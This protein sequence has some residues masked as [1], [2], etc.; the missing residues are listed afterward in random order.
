VMAARQMLEQAE[1]AMRKRIAALPPG[2]LSF[3]DYLDDDG[4]DS[5]PV[6]VALDFAIEGDGLVFDF[7]RSDPQVP[8]PINCTRNVL[9]SAVNYAVIA[10]LGDGIPVNSGCYAPVSVVA[11]LGRVVN[12]QAPAPVVNRMTIAH[13]IVN[14]V[15]GALAQALPR[16]IPAA[17][18]G[19]SYVCMLEAVREDGA[20]SI[21][22]DSEVGGWGGEPARDG[23]NAFSCGLHNIAA[24]PIEM[25]ESTHPLLFTAYALRPDSGGEGRSRG[26]VGLIREWRLEAPAGRF[27]ATFDRFTIAPY[28]LQGG[29]PGA[30]GRLLLKRGDGTTHELRSKVSDLELARGDTI[31]IETSGGGGYGPPA[32]RDPAAIAADLAHGYTTRRRP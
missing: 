17:Y 14:A 31:R 24:V 12:A 4:I 10:A 30:T 29:G 26:G 32:E 22:F 19:V 11:P 6:K 7:S 13:R 1:S 8:V 27:A 23:A 18:Y 20:R 2:R 9:V 28:G 21:Y 16:R 5:R 15:M 25:L 3:E